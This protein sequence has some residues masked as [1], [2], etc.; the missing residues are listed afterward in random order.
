MREV[1]GGLSH[2]AAPLPACAAL[3]CG[4]VGGGVVVVVPVAWLCGR[5]GSRVCVCFGARACVCAPVCE[6]VHLC[7]C[8]R[9]CA[10]MRVSARV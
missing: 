4:V 3:A 2:R 7:M 8:M 5:T 9:A 10:C 1:E 6:R